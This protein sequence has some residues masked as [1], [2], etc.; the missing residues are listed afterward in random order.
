M[1]NKENLLGYVKRK[2]GKILE[3]AELKQF[4]MSGLDYDISDE[5]V[6]CE[7]HVDYKYFQF[8]LS[9]NKKLWDKELKKG[10]I[11][12]LDGVLCHEIAHLITEEIE[13]YLKFRS[14]TDDVRHRLE[15]VTELTSKWLYRLYKN[16]N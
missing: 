6:L 2:V 10:N 14:S 12:Y 1:K 3:V 8:H 16:E 15:R 4:V 13:E 11:D 9:V 5:L 7:I